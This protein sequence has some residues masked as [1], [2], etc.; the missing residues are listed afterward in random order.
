MTFPR[1]QKVWKFQEHGDI[2][3]LCAKIEND[4]VVYMEVMEQHNSVRIEFKYVSDGYL[5]L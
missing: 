4:S 5:I 1:Y 3:L 2:T